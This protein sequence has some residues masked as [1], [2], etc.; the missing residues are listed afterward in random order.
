M[1]IRLRDEFHH[2]SVTYKKRREDLRQ[3]ARFI[4]LLRRGVPCRHTP[5]LLPPCPLRGDCTSDEPPGARS[6]DKCDGYFHSWIFNSTVGI[7][8]T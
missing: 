5:R 2:P 1:R 3:R 6:H 7:E 4:P 8:S